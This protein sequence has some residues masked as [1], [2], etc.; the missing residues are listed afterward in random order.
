MFILLYSST[1]KRLISSQSCGA[2]D[3]LEEEVQYDQ[4]TQYRGLCRYAYHYR[5]TTSM[6]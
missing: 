4:Q 2:E 1:Y 5:L 3:Q 6:V